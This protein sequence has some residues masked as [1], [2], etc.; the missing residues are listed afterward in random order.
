MASCSGIFSDTGGGVG[1]FDTALRFLAKKGARRF[2]VAGG[3]YSDLDEWVKWKRDEA[4]SQ[5]D[6][7]DLDFLADL[8]S[9]LTDGEQLE[10]P[11]AFG[12]AYELARK[13][14]EATRLSDKVLRTPEKG[15]LQYQDPS[16]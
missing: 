7:S 16:I 10:R 15:S 4:R 14:Q 3:N 1:A 6:Y 2:L 9:H 13:A 5:T 11:P 8:T 12:T